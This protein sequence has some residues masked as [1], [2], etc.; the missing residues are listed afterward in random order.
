MLSNEFKVIKSHSKCPAVVISPATW[1]SVRT[2]G[3]FILFFKLFFV[4]VFAYMPEI[5]SVATT[6]LS[7]VHVLIYNNK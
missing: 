5:K 1:K 7:H 2:S 4:L 3:F 6:G